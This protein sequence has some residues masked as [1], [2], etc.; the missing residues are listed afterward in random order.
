MFVATDFDALS[1]FDCGA[2]TAFLPPPGPSPAMAALAHTPNDNPTTRET[3]HQL[4]V[5]FFMCLDLLKN[6]LD[7]VCYGQDLLFRPLNYRFAKQ[8]PNIVDHAQN[9]FETHVKHILRYI[10]P[11]PYI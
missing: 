8:S 9:I 7:E 11:N 1:A 3:F 6:E 10:Q 4:R 5:S 2:F